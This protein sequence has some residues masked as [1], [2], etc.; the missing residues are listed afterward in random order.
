MWASI[1]KWAYPEW[2]SPLFITHPNLAMGFSPSFFM[3]AAG[4]VE[5]GLSFS[6]VWTPLCRRASALIL[7]GMFLSA[8]LEFGKIDAIG[9]SCIVALVLAIAA[10]DRVEPVPM[11]QVVWTPVGYAATLAVILLGYYELH[12]VL[13]GTTLT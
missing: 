8:V 11:R 10:D 12:S 4:A 3:Q 7:A 9:H 6:L 13:F 1:E 5:F 2:T